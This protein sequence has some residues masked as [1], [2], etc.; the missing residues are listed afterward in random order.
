MLA[1]ELILQ[2][3][4]ALQSYVWFITGTNLNI[5]IYLKY[6]LSMVYLKIVHFYL[7]SY[8]KKLPLHEMPKSHFNS[9]K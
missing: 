4:L 6:V 5:Q 3:G 9:P 1:E 7:Y 2:G 8:A